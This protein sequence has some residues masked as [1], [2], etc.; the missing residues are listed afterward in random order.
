MLALTPSAEAV[1]VTGFAG[2]VPCLQTIKFMSHTPAQTSPL[3]DTVTAD[4]SLDV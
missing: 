2:T 1:T 3:G 4:A